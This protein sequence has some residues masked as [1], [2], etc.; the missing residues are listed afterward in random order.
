M[1]FPLKNIYIY[2][3]DLPLDS[4][5]MILGQNFGENALAKYAEWGLKGHNGKDW[6]CREGE[7][8]YAAHDGVIYRLITENVVSPETNTKGL[9]IYLR[10]PLEDDKYLVTIYWHL[11][12]FKKQ[13]GDVVKAGDLIGLADNT[14]MSTGTHLHFGAKYLDKNLLTIN[15]DNG[16]EGYVDPLQFFSVMKY[17]MNA[18]GDQYILLDSLKVAI[19]IA[20]V[21]ELEEFKKHGLQE[22]LVAG[23][24]PQD[25]MVIPGIRTARLVDLFNL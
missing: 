3:K 7:P 25:F 10:A 12:E 13:V 15:Q 5:T 14:G 20:D 4:K 17:I 2:G 18:K 11:K 1:N 22:P 21:A 9:G 6:P 23:E 19:G 16:Y 24:V 8:V